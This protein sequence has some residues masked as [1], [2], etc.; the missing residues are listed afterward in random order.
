MAFCS[1]MPREPVICEVC[2]K[3]FT[4]KA[5]LVRHMYLHTGEKPFKCNLCTQSFNRKDHLRSH[6]KGHADSKFKCNHCPLTFPKSDLLRVHVLK[7]HGKYQKTFKAPSSS[8]PAATPADQE[9][10]ETPKLGFKVLTCRFCGMKFTQSQAYN[11][12]V[13]SHKRGQV[14]GADKS[15]SDNEEIVDENE[16]GIHNII[17]PQNVDLEK[18]LNAFVIIDSVERDLAQK[19]VDTA[20]SSDEGVEDDQDRQEGDEVSEKD[21]GD[22]SQDGGLEIDTGEDEDDLREDENDDGSEHQGDRSDLDPPRKMECVVCGKDNFSDQRAL[23]RHYKVH[24]R[25]FICR[26]CGIKMSSAGR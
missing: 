1:F 3:Q 6:M 13:A 19:H 7:N 10:S 21:D 2:H 16:N 14:A 24:K 9:T 26:F 4:R 22:S 20:M 5:H 17:L 18:A 25:R 11:R 12:H 8:G 23:R 15:E